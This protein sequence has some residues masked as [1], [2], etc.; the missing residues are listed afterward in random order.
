MKISKRQLKR[1]IKEEYSKLRRRGLIREMHHDT[2]HQPF[3]FDRSDPIACAE[4]DVFDN[5]YEGSVPPG[6]SPQWKKDYDDAFEEIEAEYEEHLIQQE[7]RS[8]DGYGSSDYGYDEPY[9][10]PE[11]GDSPKDREH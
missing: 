11:W 7:P 1:I 2:S 3:Q 4:Y 8:Y 5:N 6:C 10:D 9:Y